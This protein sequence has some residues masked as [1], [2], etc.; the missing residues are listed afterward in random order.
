VPSLIPIRGIC[1]EGLPSRSIGNVSVDFESGGLFGPFISESFTAYPSTDDGS[2]SFVEYK[3]AANDC[4]QWI[5][6]DGKEITISPLSFPAYGDESFAFRM[7]NE[8]GFTFDA[9]KVLVG[10]VLVSVTQSGLSTDPELQQTLVEEALSKLD[11]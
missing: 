2:L 6:E 5:A 10:E 7:A 8:E 4:P 11:R 9:V 3:S 1:K